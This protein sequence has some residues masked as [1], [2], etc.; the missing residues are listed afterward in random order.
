[1]FARVS[2]LAESGENGWWHL[3]SLERKER[4]GKIKTITSV[5]LRKKFWASCKRLF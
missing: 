2:P 5:L 4:K 3:K 1:M